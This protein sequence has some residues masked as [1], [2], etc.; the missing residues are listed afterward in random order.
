MT[1]RRISAQQVFKR[2]LLSVTVGGP[3]VDYGP[4]GVNGPLEHLLFPITHG[5]L[6]FP[7][8]DVL[9]TFCS[10]RSALASR[11]PSRH[12]TFQN[13]RQCERHL[14][15]P[16]EIRQWRKDINAAG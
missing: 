14:G 4:R 6:F 2:A 9:P 5:T 7:G 3:E 1:N 8:M 13:V 16:K 11:R 10:L 12:V 15:L